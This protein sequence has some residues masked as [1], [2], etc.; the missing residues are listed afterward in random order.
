MKVELYNTASRRGLLKGAVAASAL[1]AA[2]SLGLMIPK[3]AAQ[4]SLRAD[5]LKIP[6]VGAGQ[7]TDADWQKVGAMCL[8]P[9]KANV[10]EG[11][12][13][14]VELSWRHHFCRRL[15]P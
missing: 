2:G 15:P 7:P 8:E 14:G 5:I 3:A 1:V 4:S 6:G 12:F 11:E 10:K 13:K 9:T